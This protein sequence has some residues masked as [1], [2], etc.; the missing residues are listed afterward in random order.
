MSGIKITGLVLGT[1]TTVTATISQSVESLTGLKSIIRNAYR[2]RVAQFEEYGVAA[3]FLDTMF[4][5]APRIMRRVER[6]ILNAD[7]QQVVAFMKQYTSS[8]N[9]TGVAG[10]IIS[11]VAI[12]ALSLMRL[13]DT[14]WT[15]E[16][17]FITSLV[18]GALSVYFSTA[19]SPA[20]NGL[21]SADDIKDFLTKPAKWRNLTRLNNHLRHAE[22]TQSLTSG[23]SR[24]LP[25]LIAEERWKVPSAYA[26]IML[27]VPMTLLNV[28]LNTFLIGLGIYLGKLY[29]AELVPSYG[30]GSLGIL[31]VYIATALF[32]I[33]I[34]YTPQISKAIEDIPFERY[35]S[36]V[37]AN[38]LKM[39]E[40]GQG[41]PDV[42]GTEE[43][44]IAPQNSLQSV[45][46]RKKGNKV[47]Y[48]IIE[49]SESEMV[50]SPDP[51]EDT[52]APDEGYI[53]PPPSSSET[54]LLSHV[55]E[56]VS[57]DNAPN[58]QDA[59][60]ALIEAQEISLRASRILLEALNRSP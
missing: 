41:T 22:Q 42:N 27:V 38:K 50:A 40:S 4:P 36:I 23:L 47:G 44:P 58:V 20:F 34:F 28:A 48:E 55:A 29:T 45:H 2:D 17:F 56:S 9:M 5:D 14:H 12:T 53:K 13:Q 35:R 3:F 46:A 33:G 43:A 32:G 51:L 25:Q 59:L 37:H 39:S 30:S 8:F 60:R 21:H 11:Q 26:A 7:D 54:E 18:T 31:I 16:A 49:L 52:D 24:K 1:I 6:Y 10:A 57:S 15:A 19:L